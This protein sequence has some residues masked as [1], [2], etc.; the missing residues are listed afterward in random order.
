MTWLDTFLPRLRCPHSGEALRLASDDDKKRAGLAIEKP[1]LI[2]ENGVYVYP[3]IEGI[4]HLLPD[5]AIK[6]STV[7]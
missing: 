7:A 2:S 3:I 4:P 6:T 5:A 1:A